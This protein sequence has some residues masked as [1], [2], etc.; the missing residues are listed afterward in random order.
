MVCVAGRR[1]PAAKVAPPALP[2]GF[3]PRDHLSALVEAAATVA[4][5]TTLRGH[6]GAGKT[7]LLADWAR[8]SPVATAWVSLDPTDDRP[9]RLPAA[10]AHAVA[11]CVPDLA[12]ALVDSSPD[13]PDPLNTGRLLSVLDTLP[14]EVR[15]VL[16]DVQELT[17]PAVLDELG[18]MIRYRPGRLR[19]VLSGRTLP[20]VSLA[21][22]R[23]EGGVVDLPGERLHF[24]VPEAG[25]L[26]SRGGARMSSSQVERAHV[27]TGGWAAGLGLV[28]AAARRSVEVTGLLA[29]FP[30][31]E[32]ATAAYLRDEVLGGL[33]DDDR[34]FLQD[35]SVAT[36]VAPSLAAELSG[37]DDALPTLERLERETSL[38]TVDPRDGHHA[39][40]RLLRAWLHGELDRRPAHRARLHAR[41]GEWSAAND[42]PVEALE[43]ARAAD[44]DA[45]LARLVRGWAVPLVL[46]G[47]R[48]PLRRAWAALTPA[49]VDADPGLRLVLPALDGG[50]GEADAVA[51]RGSPTEDAAE[52]RALRAVADLAAA[53]SEPADP[54]GGRT[55]GDERARRARAAAKGA[56]AEALDGANRLFVL[57]DG[58]GA[59]ATLEVASARAAELGHHRLAQQCAALLATAA[60]LDGDASGMVRHGRRAMAATAA[61]TAA[62]AASD[63]CGR[64]GSV[65]SVSALS[66]LAYGSLLRG[67]PDEARHHAADLLARAGHGLHPAETLLMHV[68]HG[69]ADVDEGRFALGL[70]EMQGART[71]FADRELAAPQ[72]AMAAILEH[73]TAVVLER[74]AHARAVRRWLAA[75][76][77]P[78][79]E[80]ALMAAREVVA[81]RGTVSSERGLRPVLDGAVPT[82]LP[83]AAVEALLLAAGEAELAQDRARAR[84]LLIDALDGAAPLELVRPF[85]HAS[86]TVRELLAHQVGSFGAADGFARRALAAGVRG[87]SAGASALSDRESTILR[88]LP[89]LSTTTEIAEDLRVSPNTIKTQ[90]GAIYSKLGVNDRRAA[91][92]AAY[93][94]GLLAEIEVPG[95]TDLLRSG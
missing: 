55:P 63:P 62:L 5:V 60:V 47:D 40:P 82:L 67:R 69:A 81:E 26:L 37:R 14:E 42:L 84:R 75:R 23:L 32:R 35:L 13:D 54:S 61:A 59:V 85:T 21:R 30:R 90:V 28:A 41:A 88:L 11:A 43:H 58:R 33:P 56:L 64:D 65:W 53:T 39:M 71:A 93:D 38:V 89:S 72:A 50:V 4:P 20:P 45:L 79:A 66:S 87:R 52:L 86:G 17:D 51:L 2:T 70:E 27:L 57:R 73:E 74:P 78:T 34:T 24:S 15:L 92:V 22:L 6:A 9:G 77:G 48:E 16:D 76:L 46:T 49:A 36:S 25:S 80:V 3:V 29:A 10:V 31:G 8:T 18:T 1:V 95:R 44:D 12:G 83:E 19:L 91:V 68:V 94:A 7:L